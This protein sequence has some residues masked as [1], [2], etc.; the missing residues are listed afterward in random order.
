VTFVFVVSNQGNG[1][2]FIW[3]SLNM[4]NQQLLEERETLKVQV[5]D[6][7]REVKRVEDL[8]SG[9]VGG[10]T[11]ADTDR[12]TLHIRYTHLMEMCGL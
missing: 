11:Y 2:I 12:S 5:Q 3:Q 10:P 4:D 7:V 1:T 8:L 9:K 6:Y